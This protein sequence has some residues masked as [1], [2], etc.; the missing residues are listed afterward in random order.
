MNIMDMKIEE[1]PGAWLYFRVNLIKGY[2]KFL[3]GLI[4]DEQDRGRMMSVL[5]ELERSLEF[6]KDEGGKILD[7]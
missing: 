3:A 7:E 6:Y 1:M 4:K 5:S 2:A